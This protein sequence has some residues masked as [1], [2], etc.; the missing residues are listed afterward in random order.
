VRDVRV[1]IGWIKREEKLCVVCIKVMVEWLRWDESTQWGGVHGEEYRTKDRTLRNAT[2][3]GAGGRK[4]AMAPEIYTYAITN[5]FYSTA[6]VPKQL[7]WVL[8]LPVTTMTIPHC[9]ILF[10]CRLLIF[11]TVIITIILKKELKAQT[12]NCF[13]ALW[14]RI[15]WVSQWSHKGETYWNNHWIFMSRMSFLPLNL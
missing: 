1:K 9:I 4:A 15:T 13:T 10:K 5:S 11:I 8:S 6:F 12:N 7:W 14:F 2:C 3:A